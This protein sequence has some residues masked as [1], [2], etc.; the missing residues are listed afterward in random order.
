MH[1]DMVVIHACYHMIHAA[2][3]NTEQ[4]L[5]VQLVVTAQPYWYSTTFLFTTYTCYMML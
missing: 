4:G 5:N 3:A 2:S 1:H